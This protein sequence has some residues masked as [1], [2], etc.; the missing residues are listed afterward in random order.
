MRPKTPLLH[1]G[2]DGEPLIGS[3]VFEFHTRG[4]PT[5]LDHAGLDFILYDMEATGLEFGQLGDLVA[6]GRAARPLQW[7][8]VPRLRE[9]YISRSLDLGVDGVMVP[10]VRSTEEA[11]ALVDAGRYSPAGCR[12]AAF[13]L[14]HDDYS[15]R[16]DQ[17]QTQRRSNS[18]AALI[19]QLESVG[20]VED[21]EEIA[22]LDG[23]DAI[24][25]GGNDLRNDLQLRGRDSQQEFDEAF[26]HIVQASRR[27]GK[28]VGTMARD[29]EGCRRQ[30][31]RGC[32]I[33]ALGSDV[34]LLHDAYASQV[35]AL[36]G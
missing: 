1:A 2:P 33:M 36:R 13:G 17:S 23:I 31:D 3:M 10:M 32:T 19:A 5:I 12:G 34:H 24:W 26:E 8:R 15:P 6:A 7:V 20:A 11:R 9:E 25:I 35:A 22:G 16:P 4:L 30:F 27:A 18:D 21:A 28:P 14:A 29:A